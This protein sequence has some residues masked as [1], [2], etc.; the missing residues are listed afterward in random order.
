MIFV[1]ALARVGSLPGTAHAL[2]DHLLREVEILMQS[3]AVP[4]RSLGGR[5]TGLASRALTPRTV[6]GRVDEG[7]LAVTRHAPPLPVCGLLTATGNAECARDRSPLSS[8]RSQSGKRSWRPGWSYRYRS[9]AVVASSSCSNSGSTMK[10]APAVAGGSSHVLFPGPRQ[11][12]LQP[13]W[14]R[15]A[16][17]CGY[18]VFGFGC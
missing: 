2:H 3:F 12:V 1:H 17:R 8:D 5:M 9:E 16:A 18:R 13:V 15:G 11:V 6:G 4:V 14:A 7:A 10:P